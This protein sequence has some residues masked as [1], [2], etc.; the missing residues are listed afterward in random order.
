MSNP[1]PAVL[2]M[3][4]T[5]VG[6]VCNLMQIFIWILTG[7]NILSILL[8]QPLWKLESLLMSFSVILQHSAPYNRTGRTQLLY[9]LILVFL[10]MLVDFQMFFSLVK[11]PLAFP[12]LA[13]MSSSKK[14]IIQCTM[15]INQITTEMSAMGLK[16]AGYIL[17]KILSW[18]IFCTGISNILPCILQYIWLWCL[19]TCRSNKKP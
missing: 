9:S 13:L 12:N 7:Q 15:I 17:N 5:L 14:K 10:L 6:G 3:N 16:R 1:S 18:F 8:R 4:C 11:A 2:L 19:R